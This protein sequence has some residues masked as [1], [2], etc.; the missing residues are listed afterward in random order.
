MIELAKYG[1]EQSR[2][3]MANV[4]FFSKGRGCRED[5]AMSFCPKGHST[6][7]DAMSNFGPEMDVLTIL[8]SCQHPLDPEPHVC[9][10][11]RFKLTLKK[12]EAPGSFR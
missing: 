1:L 8:N 10:S 5:G 11:V 9:A 12:V 3:L 6:A 7:G 4:N 2:D